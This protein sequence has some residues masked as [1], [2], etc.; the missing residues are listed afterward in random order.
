MV[1]IHLEHTMDIMKLKHFK[2][3]PVKSQ[4]NFAMQQCYDDK[5]VL[6]MVGTVLFDIIRTSV[7]SCLL[8]SFQIS[9]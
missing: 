5:D 9:M 1:F 4:I 8:T 6:K 2:D 7:I 3:V